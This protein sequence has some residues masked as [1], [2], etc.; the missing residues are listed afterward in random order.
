MSRKF[1]LLAVLMAIVIATPATSAWLFGKKKEVLKSYYADPFQVDISSMPELSS[2]PVDDPADG[3]DWVKIDLPSPCV[4]GDGSKT[5]IMVSRGS[6]NNILIYFEGGGACTDYVTCSLTVITLHPKF[7]QSKL[8]AQLGIFNRANP[9]NPFR[10]WTFV[11][12]PYGTGD[13]HIGNRVMKY[14][15]PIFHRS[16]VVYHVGF[17]NGVVAIRWAAQQGNFDKIVIA[18]SS[19]GGYA[20]ALHFLTAREIFGKPIVVINDAGPGL[21]SERDP[22]FS[23]E[24]SI[25]SWGWDQNLPADALGYIKDGEPI[26][27]IGYVFDKYGDSLYGFFEDKKDFIIGTAFLKYTGSEFE[28]KLLKVTSDLRNMYPSNYYRFLVD[29]RL[30]T[31]L[32]LP[33]FYYLNADG[34]FLFQWAKKLVDGEPVDVVE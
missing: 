19:A 15:S 20:T 13:V 22:S 34:L 29:G 11:Y 7:W 2:M 14:Y 6:S 21:T 27:A 10:D 32:P 18:G 8:M 33:R 12:I 30:H 5:F 26:Y 17:V 9:L 28:Q 24:A 16:K 4:S 1:V 25:E 3:V 23:Y 31:A